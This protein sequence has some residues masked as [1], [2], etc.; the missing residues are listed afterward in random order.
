[1]D[2]W[3][4]ETSQIRASLAFRVRFYAR[5]AFIG[6][7]TAVAGPRPSSLNWRTV[8]YNDTMKPWGFDGR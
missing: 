2:G 7:L 5:S 6:Q 3:R 8:F 1:M 4:A